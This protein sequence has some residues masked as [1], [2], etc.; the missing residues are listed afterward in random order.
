MYARSARHAHPGARQTRASAKSGS[1][2]SGLKKRAHSAWSR[3]RSK[4]PAASARV[5]SPLGAIREPRER[6][7]DEHDARDE[8]HADGEERPTPSGRGVPPR[9]REHAERDH[10]RSGDG[11]EV[12]VVVDE[13][14]HDVRRRCGE[15]RSRGRALGAGE[16]PKRADAR[17]GRGRDE[18]DEEREAE[19]TSVGE[20]LERNAVRLDDVARVLPEALPRDL[21]RARAGALRAVVREHVPGLGPPAQAEVRIERAEPARVVHDLGAVPSR[22]EGVRR[23][24][25]GG[26]AGR[27]DDNGRESDQATADTS[28]CIRLERSAETERDERG[29]DCGA[30]EGER[31]ENGAVGDAIGAR[32]DVLGER[33]PREGPRAD[34]DRRAG[35]GDEQQ[36][37]LQPLLPHDEPERDDEDSRDHARRATA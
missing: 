2:E 24:H 22:R 12:P 25:R 18:R 15:Q 5:E 14:V 4:S 32:R 35:R 6:E 33:G 34:E 28:P 11:E 13:R 36:A 17:R 21:E 16:P 23:R 1:A 30:D 31:T 26:R 20:L 27:H 29:H 10:R 7:R 3:A 19:H 9:A 37:A 8:D